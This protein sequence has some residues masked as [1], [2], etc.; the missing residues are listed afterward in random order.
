MSSPMEKTPI[1]A[2]IV[3]FCISFIAVT[4]IH[5]QLV[6]FAKLKNIV[7]NPN[8]RKLQLHPVPVLGGLAVSFGIAVGLLGTS[9]FY[10]MTPLFI[11]I[12]CLILMVY[13]GA[14][15]DVLDISPLARL[16]VQ[17]IAVV[18]LIYNTSN[19]LALNNFHGLW[20]FEA[21]P[22]W[23]S[24]PFTIFAVVG[25][26]NALNLIDGV[27]GLISI[28]CISICSIFAFIFYS[29]NDMPLFALAVCAIGS[30]IPFLLHNAFGFESKM[31]VGDGGSLALGMMLAMLVME[32]IS[33]PEYVGVAQTHNISLVS[34]AMATLAIPV[35]DTLRVMTARI[36][37]GTSPLIGDKTHLHHLFIGL[38][39][40]HIGTASLVTLLNLS[41]VGAWYAAA[42]AGAST[43]VQFYTVI[44]AALLFDWG[45]YYGIAL[46]DK[47]APQ[48]MQ[49]F[50]TWKAAHRPPRQ[51]F[52][53][54]RRWVDKV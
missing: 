24:T 12:A 23:F 37:R 32:I 46:L 11:P 15:D 4:I 7:D 42:R 48:K 20:G 25:I 14:M 1:I 39:V 36:C 51:L 34:F 13:L 31:F 49:Q 2:A 6:R 52:D 30:L 27:D 9:L 8:T 53:F 44:V 47:I 16:M 45:I 50:R 18:A 21:L 17:I 22:E 43:D 41:V 38:G 29:A 54:I 26:I 28:F 19:S 33:N 5:P 10:D 35:F 40:S 3:A